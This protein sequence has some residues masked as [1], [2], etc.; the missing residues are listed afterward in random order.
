LFLSD[1]IFE[2]QEGSNLNIKI[3][4]SAKI[5][6]LT[7]QQGEFYQKFLQPDNPPDLIEM[8]SHLKQT[9]FAWQNWKFSVEMKVAIFKEA[10]IEEEHPILRAEIGLIHIAIMKRD[11]EQ[12]KLLMDLALEQGE[13]NLDDLL[14]QEIECAPPQGYKFISKCA[15]ISGTTA[16]H[17]A[18]CWHQES[19]AYFLESC[20]HLR[21]I[22]TNTQD[23]QINQ[24]TPLHVAAAIDD[25]TTAAT[26]LINSNVD[27]CKIDVEAKNSI[28]QTPLHV[29]AQCGSIKNVMILLFDGDSSV[30]ARDDNGKTPLHIAKTDKILEVLLNKANISD[31]AKLS[32]DDCLFGHILKR[33]PKCIETYLDLM[34][35]SKNEDAKVKERQ[36]T[37]HL[38]TFNHD[39]ERKSNYLDKHK[40]LINA[41]YPEHLRHPVM[42]FFAA[43]KWKP[44]RK[45]YMV[46]F[47][48]FFSFLIALTVHGTN[49]I[50]Y[51]QLNEKCHNIRSKSLPIYFFVT[52]PFWY[53]Y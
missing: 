49:Q 26:L 33:H 37:F 53:E 42:K 2:D 1:D 38:E 44:H 39:T 17:L 3:E 32:G 36:Y 6:S 28:G 34:V 13:T 40:K 45:K 25:D 9:D 30:M 27:D 43:M 24:F 8:K 7:G 22:K 48:V 10:E 23:N 50:D 46:N 16:I 12:V 51:L 15:W 31:L 47:L 5:G 52:M 14:K 21:N 11:I 29:A 18:T 19:L 20:P 41:G 4:Q 35:S